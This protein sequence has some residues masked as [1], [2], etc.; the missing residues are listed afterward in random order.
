MKIIVLIGLIFFIF[1]IFK[2]ISL[3]SHIKKNK[4]ETTIDLEKDPKTKEY[5]PKE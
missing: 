1:L 4:N 5:K 2:M 3:R